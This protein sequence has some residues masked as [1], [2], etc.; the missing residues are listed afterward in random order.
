M[1]TLCKYYELTVSERSLSRT[2]RCLESLWTADPRSRPTSHL[3]VT[4]RRRRRIAPVERP[5]TPHLDCPR[6]SL[7]PSPSLA[8]PNRPSSPIFPFRILLLLSM[9][10]FVMDQGQEPGSSNTNNDESRRSRLCFPFTV[11]R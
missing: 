8:L 5:Y 9:V 3:S 2:L 11:P 6:L 10:L 7:A 1:S 4:P